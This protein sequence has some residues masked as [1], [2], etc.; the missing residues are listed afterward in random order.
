MATTTPL[1]IPIHRAYQ[2]RLTEIDWDNLQL[3]QHPSDHMLVCDY[4]GGEWQTPEIRPYG[5]LSLPPA[6]LALHYGQ[7]IFEGMK[8]FRMADGRVQ[9]FRPDKHYERFTRSADLLCLAVTPGGAFREGLHR[10]VT[11]VK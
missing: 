5:P 2:S 9:I 4:T 1:Y 6:T 7:T 8:A 3:G 10:L 11:V